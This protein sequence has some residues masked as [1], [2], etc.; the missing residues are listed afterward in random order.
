MRCALILSVC[1][2]LC[3]AATASA[4]LIPVI[5]TAGNIT[6]GCE[7]TPSG[8]TNAAG[9]TVPAGYDEVDFYLTGMTGSAASRSRRATRPAG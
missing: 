2:V 5:V 1:V 9:N 4:Y 3:G 8:G 6:V 7:R